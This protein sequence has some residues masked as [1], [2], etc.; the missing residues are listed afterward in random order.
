MIWDNRGVVHRVAPI[1]RRLATRD[2]PHDTSRRRADPMRRTAVVT[3]GGSGIGARDRPTVSART[4]TRSRSGILPPPRRSLPGSKQPAGPRSGTRSTPPT[5]P[6]SNPR[7]TTSAH[8][9]ARRPSSSIAPAARPGATSSGS[10]PRSG[11]RDRRQPHERVPLLPGLH[12]RHARRALGPDRQH[13]LLLHPTGVPRLGAVR[14][15]E[16]GHGRPHEI[17][18]RSSSHRTGSPSTPSRPALSTHRRLAARSREASS[19]FDESLE[20]TPVGRVGLPED[21]ANACSFLVSEQASYITG[22]IIPVNGGRATT[23]P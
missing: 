12:P 14:G 8:G 1:R 21:I 7:Q 9:S 15:R 2:A 18:R 10:P 22:Q 23:E 16:G 11:S 5:A 3:G 19:V 20:H 4:A 6:P 17:A 13:L